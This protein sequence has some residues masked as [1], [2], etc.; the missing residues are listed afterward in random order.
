M[1][2]GRFD[3]ADVIFRRHEA[4]EFAGIGFAE[5][6]EDFRFAARG[7]DLGVVFA[8]FHQR[9]LL[10]HDLAGKCNRAVAQAAFRHDLVDQPH[11]KAFLGGHMLAARHHFKRLLHACDARQALGAAR[12]GQKA[13]IHFRKAAFRT[14]HRHAVVGAQG[15]F[16]PAAQCGAMNGSH[17]RLWRIFHRGLHIVQAR[18]LHRAAEF[19][20]VGTGN[21]GPPLA[22]QNDGLCVLVGNGLFETFGQSVPHIRRQRVDRRRVERQHGNVAVTRKIGYGIDGGHGVSF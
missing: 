6:L 9:P 15:H 10:G 5:I 11:R 7:F 21:K 18:P 22:N 19:G 17:H 8:H 12:T 20:N 14:R 16:Q 2:H 3:A 1:V 4:A 13:D